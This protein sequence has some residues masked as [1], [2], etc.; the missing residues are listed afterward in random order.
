MSATVLYIPCPSRDS[1]P[2]RMR[3][4]ASARRR[5]A[6][7]AQVVPDPCRRRPLRDS[8]ASGWRQRPSSRRLHGDPGRS[9]P[10]GGPSSR[11]TGGRSPRRR[12]GFVLSRRGARH[13][14]G[15]VAGRLC[16]RVRTAISAAKRAPA[17]ENVLVHGAATAHLALAAGVLDELKYAQWWSSGGAIRAGR[18]ARTRARRGCGGRRSRPRAGR[19][20]RRSR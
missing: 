20:C 9:S 10:A 16:E 19:A 11:L 15:A 6:P 4:R 1:S 17:D 3:D 13:G 18:G 8:R 2:G 7:P 5:Q 12:V 14:N